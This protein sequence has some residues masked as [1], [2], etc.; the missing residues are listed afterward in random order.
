MATV[1][2]TVSIVHSDTPPAVDV[3]YYTEKTGEIL[4]RLILIRK[5]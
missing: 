1:F 3:E 4:A 2:K 5:V